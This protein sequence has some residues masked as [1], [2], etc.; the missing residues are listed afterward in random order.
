VVT[1]A[2]RPKIFKLRRILL[3]TSRRMNDGDKDRTL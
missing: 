2:P 1:R 3:V